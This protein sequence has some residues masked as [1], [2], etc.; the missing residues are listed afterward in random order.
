MDIDDCNKAAMSIRSREWM[1]MML[2]MLSFFSESIKA[3]PA[4]DNNFWDI[5]HH[6]IKT[7]K[8]LEIM[9]SKTFEQAILLVGEELCIAI[10]R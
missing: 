7:H 3:Y 4:D 2:P 9:K 5:V 6:G 1:F 10:A 8:L